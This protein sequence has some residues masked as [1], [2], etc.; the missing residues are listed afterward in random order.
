MS[1]VQKCVYAAYLRMLKQKHKNTVTEKDLAGLMHF[2]IEKP[3]H[4]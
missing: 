2:Y 1:L 4:D 3:L